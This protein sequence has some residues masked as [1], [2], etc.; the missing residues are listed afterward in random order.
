MASVTEEMLQNIASEI[1]REFNSDGISLTEGVKKKASDNGFNR[2]Q[3]ARLIER[4]NSEAF[5]SMFPSK[6]DFVVA[7]P[8]EVLG[9]KVASVQ[10]EA[11][12]TYKQSVD[13]DLYE[14][15]GISPSEKVASVDFVEHTMASTAMFTEIM[16]LNRMKDEYRIDKLARDIQA[17]ELGN[18]F[19]TLVKEAVY[20]ETPLKDIEVELLQCFPESTEMVCDVV[21]EIATKLASDRFLPI[22]LLER[23]ADTDLDLDMPVIEGKFAA[24]LRGVMEAYE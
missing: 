24:A 19:Y 23:A 8:K 1:V 6:T 22:H 3:T 4:T 9:E 20:A 12:I 21:D 16:E 15:F 18:E 2:D 14:V 5:L 13:R 11:R 7:D 10:K 17:E